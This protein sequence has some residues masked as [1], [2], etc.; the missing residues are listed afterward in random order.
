M[1]SAGVNVVPMGIAWIAI[2]ATVMLAFRSRV[3]SFL[4]RFTDSGKAEEARRRDLRIGVTLLALFVYVLVATGVA[5][6]LIPQQ[7]SVWALGI[8]LPVAFAVNL[9]YWVRFRS[10]GLSLVAWLQR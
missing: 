7:S 8:G 2:V 1:S 3:V 9:L 10:A 5:L 4:I 6:L